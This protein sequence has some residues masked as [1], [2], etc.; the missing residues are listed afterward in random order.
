MLGSRET[1]ASTWHFLTVQRT[2]GVNLGVTTSPVNPFVFGVIN[3]SVVFN[4]LTNLSIVS[5]FFYFSTVLPCTCIIDVFGSRR[6]SSLIFESWDVLTP[7]LKLVLRNGP[8]TTTEVSPQYSD[9]DPDAFYRPVTCSSPSR[10]VQLPDNTPTTVVLVGHLSP[11]SVGEGRD[12]NVRGR[13]YGITVFHFYIKRLEV[14][15]EC[16]FLYPP[17]SRLPIM[18][19]FSFC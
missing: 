15:A 14:I 12:R 8:I 13:S 16:F 10:S 19:K 4:S 17:K 2:K 9:Q 5:W 6:L 18:C 3:K 7:C 11:S 1:G